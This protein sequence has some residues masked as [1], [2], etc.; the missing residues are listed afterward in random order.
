[1]V[2]RLITK[3]IKKFAG[4]IPGIDIDSWILGGKNVTTEGSLIY[5]SVRYA[6]ASN[7]IESISFFDIA[8]Q[9]NFQLASTLGHEMTHM[10]DITSGNYAKWYEK[11]GKFFKGSRLRMNQVIY[12]AEMNAYR[13]EI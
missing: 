8:F 9:S 1:M 3:I 11:S 12:R 2:M 5:G 4:K 13:W 10:I 6:F 7:S